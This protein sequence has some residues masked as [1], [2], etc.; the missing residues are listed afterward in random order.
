MLAFLN[1]GLKAAFLIPAISVLW[2]ILIGGPVT[3]LDISVPFTGNGL[4]GSG[5]IIPLQAPIT[6]LANTIAT[7]VVVLPFMAPL[8]NIFI[9]GLQVKLALLVISIFQWILGLFIQN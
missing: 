9:W 5:T 4:S 3:S 6:L 1:I 7:I 2:S 8:F